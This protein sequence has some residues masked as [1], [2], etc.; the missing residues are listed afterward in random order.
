MVSEQL[1]DFG[2]GR[3]RQ[4]FSREGRINLFIQQTARNASATDRQRQRLALLMTINVQLDVCREQALRGILAEKSFARV[5]HQERQL[6]DH[7]LYSS[8]TGAENLQQQRRHRLEIDV[9]R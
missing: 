4:D 9:I 3:Q 5:T 8:F 1:S 2:R 7:C 6:I